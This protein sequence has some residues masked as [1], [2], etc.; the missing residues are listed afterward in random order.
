MPTTD[1]DTATAADTAD[2][3]AAADT[4][5]A[6][7]AADTATAPETATGSTI[8]P[9]I[10]ER[11]AARVRVL[12]ALAHPTRLFLV[13]ELARGEGCVCE[14][15]ELVGHDVSTV[16]KHL[17]VLRKAGVIGSERRGQQIYYHLLVPCVLDVF[18]C[19]AGVLDESGSATGGPSCHAGC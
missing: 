18:D 9:S 5:D 10:A 7:A 19:V 3:P 16:S 2:A 15:T 11:Y 8:A 12:K 1:T 6:T 17:T 14:L 13:E 4:A